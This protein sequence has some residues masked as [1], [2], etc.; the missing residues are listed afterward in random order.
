MR[1]CTGNKTPDKTSTCTHRRGGRVLPSSEG[2]LISGRINCTSFSQ[3]WWWKRN[4]SP[5]KTVVK[6]GFFPGYQ[7]ENEEVWRKVEQVVK[8]MVFTIEQLVKS[9]VFTFEQ[10][11]KST[12]FTISAKVKTNVQWTFFLYIIQYEL[13]LHSVQLQN[14]SVAIG[15]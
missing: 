10:V 11:V 5:L 13:A 2:K 7:G 8:S 6:I 1:H 9:L 12:V 15:R 14:T 3:H 4:F